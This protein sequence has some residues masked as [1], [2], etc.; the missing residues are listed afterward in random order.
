YGSVNSVRTLPE[1]FCA[2]VNFKTKEAA[3]KAMQ[4]LQGAECG[5]Q[6]LLI[7]FPDNPIVNSGTLTIRK[8]PSTSRPQQRQTFVGKAVAAQYQ[9]STAV[10]ITAVDQKNTTWPVNGYKCYFWRTTGCSFGDKC[11]N[12]HLSSSKGVDKKPWQKT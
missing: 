9:N 7:K 4:S 2:F 3:G 8:T 12:K 5:G 10:N 1:K 6:K 11:R